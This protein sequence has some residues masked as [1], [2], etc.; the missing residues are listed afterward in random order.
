MREVGPEAWPQARPMCARCRRPLR[1]CYCA[2]LPTLATQT[3]IVILQH[4]REKDMPIGTARMAQ[5]CL[6]EAELHLGIR[7]G[8]SPAFQQAI[9]EPARPAAPLSP[10]PTARHIISHTPAGPGTHLALHGT[11][12]QA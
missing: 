5:L 11:R 9:S 4:P 8:E 7:R 10:G 3:R 1:V 2:A 12:S 6:P